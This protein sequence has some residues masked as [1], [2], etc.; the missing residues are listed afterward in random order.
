MPESS[1]SLNTRLLDLP[2]FGF[3]RMGLLTA[4]KLA[5]GVA[6]IS[7]GKDLNHVTV[8]DLL[9]YLPMRY[10]DRSKLT[11]IRDLSDGIETSLELFVKLSGGK[12]VGGWRRSFRQRLYKFQ[13]SATDRER[14][15]KDVV[16]WMFVSGISAPKI[17]ENYEKKFTRGVR[18]I[19]F[20]KWEWDATQQTYSL[21]LNKPDEIEILPPLGEALATAAPHD[22]SHHDAPAAIHVGRRVPVYR[23]INDIRP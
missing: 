2:D 22:K 4:R 3:S 1:I 9:H 5:A 21:R 13:I 14:S 15:G 10:E 16:V 6:D 11:S 20:G 7:T 17:I 23:K 18:F 8:E 19:A 12:Q